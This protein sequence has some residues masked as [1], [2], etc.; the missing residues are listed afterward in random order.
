V[1]Y[2]DIKTVEKSKTT[3]TLVTS[4]NRVILTHHIE[5]SLRSAKICACGTKIDV[6]CEASVNFRHI[7]QNATPTEFAPCPDNAICKY[8]QHDT[9]K[10][11]PAPATQNE[12]G[13]VQSAAPARKTGTHLFKTTQKF[14]ACHTK[15]FSIRYKTSRSATPATR[16]KATRRLKLPK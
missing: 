1:R 11:L 2:R 9:S 14:C 6:S 8:T 4:L 16:N 12:D 10:G 13:H 7:S 5:E 3:A 15:R